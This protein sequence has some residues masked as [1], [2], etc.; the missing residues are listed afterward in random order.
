MKVVIIAGGRGSR[1]GV[2]S[3]TTPKALL[4][5]AGKSLLEHQFKLLKSQG[6]N[7]VLILTNYLGEKIREF[8]GDGSRFGLSVRC[9]SEDQPLGTAGAVRA[10][11]KYLAN[12]FLVVYGDELMNVDFKRLLNYHK[13]Q[14]IKHKSLV[15]TLAVHPNDH[16]F[17][18][19]LVEVGQDGLI[20]NFLTKPHKPDLLFRNLAS[21]PVYVLSPKIFKYIP[22]NTLVDFG[23]QVFPTVLKRGA[24]LAAYSTPEYIKDIGTPQRIQEA[25]AAIKSGKFKAGSLR[26]KRPAI[27]LDRD[28]VINK[29]VGDLRRV[30]NFEL[31]PGSVEAI[32]K[33]NHSGYYAIV[34]TNQPVVA[35]GFCTMEELLEI[36]KKMETELAKTGAKLDAIYFCPHHPDKGFPGE[37]KKYKIVC[38]C[39]KPKID[40]IKLATKDFNI[41]LKK[42]YTIGDRTADYELAQ[43]AGL[44]FIGV[45]TGYALKDGHYKIVVRPLLAKNLFSAVKK[46]IKK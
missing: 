22:R 17:D 28:G 12:D 39:R 40:M 11:E 18:S 8:A 5:V 45:K 20:T 24:N 10:A 38:R 33:I 23:R 29:E 6:F 41:D 4:K 27:F 30:K 9:I 34:I 21:T 42:S 2:V 14:K 16:P 46:I 13:L 36:H 7:Q 15:G 19:N 31:L 37:N 35:K 1:M 25:E 32:K 3:E 44:K 43:R 26:T